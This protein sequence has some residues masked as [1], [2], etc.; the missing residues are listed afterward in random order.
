MSQIREEEREDKLSSPYVTKQQTEKSNTS[1]GPKEADLSY[2]SKLQSSLYF[3]PG[4]KFEKIEVKTDDDMLLSNSYSH[5]PDR[6][7]HTPEPDDKR[8]TRY[9]KNL[10]KSPP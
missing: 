2:L 3:E 8:E 4:K 1:N 6:R 9:N 7:E 5:K 10:D